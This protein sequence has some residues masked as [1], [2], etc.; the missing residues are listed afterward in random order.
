MKEGDVM[1]L[2]NVVTRLK[3]QLGLINIATPFKDLDGTI[4]T[5][6]NEITLPVFSTYSPY[7]ESFRFATSD[8][9][10]LEKGANY[11]IFLLP[12]WSEKKLLYV[13][14]VRYDDT[15]LSGLGY[16]GGGFPMRTGGIINQ[17]MLSTAGAQVM[18][19][20]IPKLTFRWEEPRKLTIWNMYSS[21]KIIIDAGIVH[22][23]SLA[24]I[25]ETAK[26]TFMKLA[27]LDL[28]SNLYPTLKQYT[29]INS[30]IGNINLKLDNWENAESERAEFINTLD[31]TYHLDFQPI[32]YI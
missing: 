21:T 14:D 16:Y 25:P 29:E 3:L 32:Y 9:E 30:A 4:V 22:D 6:L 2:S 27:L 7:K 26:E 24:S 31:D 15:C 17:A 13:F 19:M 20:M 23:K 18:N 11:D 12:D 28:K 5:I 10:R 1:N 8:L